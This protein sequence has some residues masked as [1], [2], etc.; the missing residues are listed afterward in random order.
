MI[1][2]I[3]PIDFQFPVIDPFL[4]CVHHYDIYPRGIKNCE[5][6][7]KYLKGRNVGSDF[8]MKDNFRLYHGD[9]VTGFPVH[10]HRGFETITIVRKGYIDHSDSLGASARYG[11]GDV[12]W[13]TAGA[14]I[15]HSEMFPLVHKDQ[16]N[17]VELFQIWLNLPR[18]KKMVKPNFKMLWAN[19]LPKINQD[20][21]DLTI[22]NGKYN[23]IEFYQAP[24][25]SY[26]ASKENN[27]NIFNIKLNSHSSMKLEKSKQETNRVLY[28][29]SEGE[30][31]INN[32][33]HK[34][35]Q[36]FILD[37][38][39]DLEIKNIGENLVELL[40]L[41]ARPLKETVA[42]YGPFVMNTQQEIMQAFKDYQQT[43][44]GGW[45]WK[46]HDPV[47]GESPERFAKFSDGKILKPEIKG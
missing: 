1:K 7:P 27:I 8:T 26:A 21:L 31:E 16:E 25:D 6:D 40:W 35:H 5:L 33:K 28:F 22:I 45:P 47:H 24:E 15:Q 17:T 46:D 36:A 44:F 4:F 43:Q 38:Q 18:A 34:G 39:S 30:I 14:G 29:F 32:E 20:G 13:L 23:E 3:I 9:R 11:Q 12:Q 10:P 42:Q 37:W 41:E 2:K 19:D